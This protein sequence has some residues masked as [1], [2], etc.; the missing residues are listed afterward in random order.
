MNC[1]S[2]N[3]DC[4]FFLDQ[5]DTLD[6]CYEDIQSNC[7]LPMSESQILKVKFCQDSAKSLTVQIDNCLRPSKSNESCSCFSSLNT[8]NLLFVSNCSLTEEMRIAQSVKKNCTA[9]EIYQTLNHPHLQLSLNKLC[10]I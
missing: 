8:T 5:L 10:P 4:F 6:A 7:T 2:S 1:Q 9:G 3:L